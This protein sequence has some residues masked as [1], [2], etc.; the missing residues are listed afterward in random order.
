MHWECRR[1]VYSGRSCSTYYFINMPK[2]ARFLGLAVILA[3]ICNCRSTG[4]PS[5]SLVVSV[6]DQRMVLI[7]SGAVVRSYPVSTSKFGL[8]STP[9]SYKTPLGEMY[10]YQKIGEGAR[11]GTVF[12]NRRPTGEVVGPDA[13]GRDPIVSR[14]LWLEGREQSNSNTKERLIYIHGTPEERT[15]GWPTS[16]GCIRMKSSDI[17]D[18]YARVQRGTGVYIKKEPLSPEEIPKG[19]RVLWAAARPRS[20]LSLPRRDAVQASNIVYAANDS[21]AALKT[22]LVSVPHHEGVFVR[23]LGA[24]GSGAKRFAS[25]TGKARVKP[26]KRHQPG[27]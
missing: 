24:A 21:P 17:I 18:L 13:P 27:S 1:R 6:D 15:I 8:G 26:V 5:N 3:V 7:N 10:V 2:T 12:K 11:A 4:L 19:E 20:F 25:R 23:L 14:I 16:Y 9:R 22:N